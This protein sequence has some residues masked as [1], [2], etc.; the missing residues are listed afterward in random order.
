[1][2]TDTLSTS[3]PNHPVTPQRP[4]VTIVM[5]NYNGA[6][7]LPEAL[8]SAQA[9][10]LRDIEIVVSDDGSTDAS[11]AIVTQAMA[12]DARIRLLQSRQNRGAAA[13]RNSALAVARGEWIAV[14][15]SDDLMHPERL[16]RLV[17]AAEHDCAELVAD[18][19]IEFHQDGSAPARR[20]LRGHW[21]TGP[22]SIDMAEYVR[23]NLFYVRAP[24]LGYL[25]PLFRASILANHRYDETL[26]VGEDYDLVVR[27]LHAGKKLRVYPQA[28]YFYR[29]H[30]ASLSRQFNNN[31]L[32]ALKAANERL[33]A[34]LSPEDLRGMA[35][36]VIRQRSIETALLF[37][38]LLAALKSR[39]WTNAL[40][41]AW[42]R[43]RVLVL[44]QYPVEKRLHGVSSLLR[45][46]FRGLSPTDRKNV[47]L[48][49]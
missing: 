10:T 45:R 22:R 4:I 25:K 18:N 47:L 8:Q 31:A 16:A 40:R 32:V 9:Q 49:T 13:A 6:A 1:M 37:D 36:L 30:R 20:L 7:Y 5:A 23:R 43:P 33:L 3:E 2:A 48:R 12:D 21:L 26:A 11:V 29:Q 14:M 24:A 15:D 38:K 39:R 17:R 46:R 27:F 41:I 28:F 44:L 34:S 19:V 35:A 42:R